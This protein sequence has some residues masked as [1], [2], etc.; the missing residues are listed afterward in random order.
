MLQRKL[1]KPNDFASTDELE[2]RILEF[3]HHYQQA[4]KPFSW[5]FTRTD[6]DRLLDK[7]R[8]NEQLQTRAA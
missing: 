8:L 5:K 2:A 1:L 3:Q 4:A 7:L 6:L